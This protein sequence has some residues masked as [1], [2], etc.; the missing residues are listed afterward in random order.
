MTQEDKDIQKLFGDFK[1]KLSSEA[2]FLQQLER[3]MDG[4]EFLRQA[5]QK[6]LRAYR[7]AG[8]FAAAAGFLCGVLMTLLVPTLVSFFDTLKYTAEY[9][10]VIAWTIAGGA[11][12]A[13]CLTTFLQSLAPS[14]RIL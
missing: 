10:T 5:S 2:D 1:P 6:N 7:R 14:R 3:R 11:T 12:F 8:V 9:S 13:V 4:V